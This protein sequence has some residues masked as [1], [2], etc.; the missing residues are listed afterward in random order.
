MDEVIKEEAKSTFNFKS[1]R[2]GHSNR[3][4]GETAV[5]WEE[6]QESI[7]SFK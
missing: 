3:D 2:E 6:I 1:Q 5:M 4:Q 7:Q